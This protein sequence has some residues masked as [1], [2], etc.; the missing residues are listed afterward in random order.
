MIDLNV[1]KENPE[2]AKNIKLEISGA[3]LLAFGESIHNRAIA[4]AEKIAPTSPEKYLTPQELADTLHVSL[5]T[6][7]SWDKSGITKPVRIGNAKRYRLSDVEKFMQ[8]DQ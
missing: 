3:D 8:E 7:W 2:L 1:L 5:V 6:L 4:E